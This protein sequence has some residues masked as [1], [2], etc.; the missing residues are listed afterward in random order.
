[1]KTIDRVYGYL[2]GPNTGLCRKTGKTFEEVMH[3]FIISGENTSIIS[4]SGKISI[5]GAKEQKK[6]NQSTGFLSVNYDVPDWV[7]WREQH[8]SCISHEW[9]AKVCRIYG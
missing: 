4:S 9:E 7:N 3:H 1:M 2:R 5:V 8:T 6:R